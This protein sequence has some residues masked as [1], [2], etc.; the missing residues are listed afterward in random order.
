MC[1]FHYLNVLCPSYFGN[2]ERR[3]RK[4]YDNVVKYRSKISLETTAILS[5]LCI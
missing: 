3:D 1:I 4:H 5:F 2:I